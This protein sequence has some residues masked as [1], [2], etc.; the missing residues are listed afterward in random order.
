MHPYSRM[1]HLATPTA[2]YSRVQQEQWRLKTNPTLSQQ[3]RHTTSQNLSKKG[4]RRQFIMSKF[5]DI[6]NTLHMLGQGGG[7]SR[8]SSEIMGE[9]KSIK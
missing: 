7:R 5:S 2:Y 8:L 1:Q 9:I 6:E 4:S 3:N